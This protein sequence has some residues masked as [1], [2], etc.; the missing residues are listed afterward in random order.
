MGRITDWF[1]RRGAA[2]RTLKLPPEGRAL[3]L[4]DL[5]GNIDD[6][7]AF[8]SKSRA[9]ERLEAGE[10]LWLLITGD[11]PDVRRHQQVDS[12]VP[13]DGDVQIVDDL[14]ACRT[15]LGERG[16][17]IVYLEGNHDFHVA[18]IVGEV[19]RYHAFQREQGEPDPGATALGVS[20]ADYEAYCD[21]YRETYGESVFMNNIGP[22][23]MVPRAKAPH[24]AF[25]KSGPILA[26]LG[27]S[28]IMVTH[29]GP[30]RMERWST[31]ELRRKIDGADA[32]ILRKSAPEAYFESP[33][34]QLL[35][36]RFRNG[37]YT[38]ADLDAFLKTYEC[39]MLVTGHTPHPYLVDFDKR[40]PLE[41][42]EFREGIGAIGGQQVVLCTS[43]GAFQQDCK[44]YLEVDL[45]QPIN[46]FGGLFDADA[47]HPVY[48][49]EEGALLPGEPLPGAE[50]VLKPV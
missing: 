15:R 11:I 17:R 1:K 16:N 35:N 26:V 12:R 7:R 48:S 8:L 27:A 14:I 6:W 45:T 23:D 32:E 22:Y 19:T 2:N 50:I 4:S 34:H 20:P 18:R 24:L 41:G 46:G 10:D 30:P 43:F 42:C 38:L 9:F 36:N 3:I 33:Y 25:L 49:V 13:A 28:G 5:H 31:R 21:Y 40:A 29:A 37:D 44:R 39:E 47:V